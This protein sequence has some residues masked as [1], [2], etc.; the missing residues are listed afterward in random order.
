[1]RSGRL[2]ERE[3][4]TARLEEAVAAYR[5]ALE[6]R[7]ASGFRS[8]W[9]ASFGNQGVA[10]ML[11]ADRTNDAALAETAVQQIETAYET[12]RSGGQEHVGGRVPG[13][14]AE[15]AG[16]PRPAQGQVRAGR[17][18]TESSS[19]GPSVSEGRGDPERRFGSSSLDRFA[20]A[21]DDDSAG[22]V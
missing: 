8:D 11:I 10:L 12:E 18:R 4:G 20:Y 17:L 15:S 5:A 14:T 6:E 22:P 2:G 16:D 21:R 3:S 9:A 1:M 7:R 13:A 19:R